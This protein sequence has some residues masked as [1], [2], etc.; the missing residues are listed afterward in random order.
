MAC[1]PRGESMNPSGLK[2]VKAKISGKLGGAALDDLAAPVPAELQG[3]AGTKASSVC[4]SMKHELCHP[5]PRGGRE[6]DF[7]TQGKR[8]GE[9]VHHVE[10]VDLLSSLS[11]EPV[12]V[13]A[14]VAVCQPSVPPLV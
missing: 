3:S 4:M 11:R 6:V 8:G 7:S 1:P 2:P 14:N 5:D 9:Q 10:R 12:R 13:S